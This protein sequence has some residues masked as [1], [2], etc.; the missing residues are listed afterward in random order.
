MDTA[1]IQTD[2]FQ[3]L[4]DTCD[5][6]FGV[7]ITVPVMAI[8]LQSASDHHAIGAILKGAQGVNH[9]QLA[10]ARQFD[11]LDGGRVV[12]AQP[13]GQIGS[14]IGTVMAGKGDYLGGP[15]LFIHRFSSSHHHYFVDRDQVKKGINFG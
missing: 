1:A 4:A 9:I 8:A 2:L 10:A 3:Q 6:S 13:A 7:Y 15:R 11:D 12:Q 5:S 14:G